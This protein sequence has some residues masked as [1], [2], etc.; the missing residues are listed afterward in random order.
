[1]LAAAAICLAAFVPDRANEYMV[2]AAEASDSR[3]LGGIHYWFDDADGA[4]V[5]EAAAAASLRRFALTS[6]GSVTK[7]MRFDSAAAR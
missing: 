2:A 1:M 7:M 3:L 4:I 5:G 6:T